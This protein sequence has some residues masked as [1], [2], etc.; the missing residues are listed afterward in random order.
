M[1]ALKKAA[2]FVIYKMYCYNLKIPPNA[3]MR[4]VKVKC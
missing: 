3:M 1:A 4:W 2:I